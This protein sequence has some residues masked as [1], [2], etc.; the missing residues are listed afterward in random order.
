MNTLRSKSPTTAWFTKQ[1]VKGLGTLVSKLQ[2]RNFALLRTHCIVLL[3]YTQ[4]HPKDLFLKISVLQANFAGS[5]DMWKKQYVLG[6]KVL[7]RKK[8]V[9]GDLMFR[10]VTMCYGSEPPSP[11]PLL[12][13][14][15]CPMTTPKLA[16]NVWTYV[17]W[18]TSSK[19]GCRL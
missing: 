13:G 14:E 4:G 2:S 8:C 3:G 17:C 12:R 7:L 6:R 9:W 5:L 1:V 11:P 19:P 16:S 15:F 18:E 10:I